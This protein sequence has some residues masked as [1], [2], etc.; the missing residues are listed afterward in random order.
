MIQAFVVCCAPGWLVVFLDVQL[1]FTNYIHQ[2]LLNLP[3]VPNGYLQS[4]L[5]ATSFCAILSRA[6]KYDTLLA[7]CCLLSH[8][9]IQYDCT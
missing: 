5:Q 6:F 8:L 7:V 3:P 4:G 1:N 9:V 2:Y